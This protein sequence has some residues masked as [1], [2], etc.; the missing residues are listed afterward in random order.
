MNQ[1][2]TPTWNQ[3][4]LFNNIPLHGEVKDIAWDP[5][6]IVIELYDDD[7]LVSLSECRLFFYIHFE[8][9]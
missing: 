5:P 2:L 4:L 9:S 6:L 7:A 1:T 3:M 8:G